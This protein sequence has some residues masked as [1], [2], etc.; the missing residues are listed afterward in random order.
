MSEEIKNYNINKDYIATVDSCDK[1]LD[2]ACTTAELLMNTEGRTLA[3]RAAGIFLTE[4]LDARKEIEELKKMIK[5]VN[6]IEENN[7]VINPKVHC[8]S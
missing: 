6:Y 8:V 2:I 1:H 4:V 7:N 3:G 5:N